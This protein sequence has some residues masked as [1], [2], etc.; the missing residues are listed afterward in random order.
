MNTV[1]QNP[2]LIDPRAHSE[3]L[4]KLDSTIASSNEHLL[5]LAT[6]AALIEFL[7]HKTGSSTHLWRDDGGRMIG[8]MTLV[9]TPADSGVELLSIGVSPELQGRGYGKQMLD[10]AVDYA[11]S[12]EKNTVWLATNAENAGALNFYQKNGFEHI[13][14]K[15]DYYGNGATYFILSRCVRR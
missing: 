9:S 14:T 6:S 2:S 1:E 11:G 4:F 8:F 5:E 3:E 15:N 7:T 13:A 10:F 12:C